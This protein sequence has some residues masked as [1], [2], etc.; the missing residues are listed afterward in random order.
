MFGGTLVE[1]PDGGPEELGPALL[2][3]LLTNK[4]T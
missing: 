4:N 1:A 2:V 3:A